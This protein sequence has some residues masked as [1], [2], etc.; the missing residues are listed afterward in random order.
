MPACI[1]PDGGGAVE[2]LLIEIST[3]GCRISQV[4]EARIMPGAPVTVLINGFAGLAAEV[5]RAHDALVGL[6]FAKP[7]TRASLTQ[8][9]ESH[10]DPPLQLRPLF[11]FAT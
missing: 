7:L 3:Q 4:D 8:I 11:R 6:R 1:E 2:G 10:R 9:L 5:L